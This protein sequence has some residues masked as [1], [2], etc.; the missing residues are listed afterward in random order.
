MGIQDERGGD[1]LKATVK[2]PGPGLRGQR[3]RKPPEGL[4]AMHHPQGR[5][6]HLLRMTA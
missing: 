5:L 6:S 1:G 3:K 2:R 4:W